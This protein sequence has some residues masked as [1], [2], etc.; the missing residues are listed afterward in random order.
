MHCSAHSS[1]KLILMDII[2]WI[3]FNP[4]HSDQINYYLIIKENERHIIVYML[5]AQGVDKKQP[6]L[7]R[8]D[9]TG[10]V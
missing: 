9:S 7:T 1:L 10:N 5:V 8:N 2:K 3:F 6:G 4:G